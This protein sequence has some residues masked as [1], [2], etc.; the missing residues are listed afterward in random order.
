MLTFCWCWVKILK[1][2]FVQDL[3]LNLQYDFGKMNSTLGSVVPLAM[4][5]FC[6]HLVWNISWAVSLFITQN[7]A[8]LLEI[9]EMC[10]WVK[11]FVLILPLIHYS[12]FENEQIRYILYKKHFL[13]KIYFSVQ[14]SRPHNKNKNCLVDQ[15]WHMSRTTSVASSRQALRRRHILKWQKTERIGKQITIQP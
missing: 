15:N 14:S 1:M 11:T 9:I 10:I 13:V 5:L 4:F 3:C 12:Q 6:S 8:V 7:G 2:K